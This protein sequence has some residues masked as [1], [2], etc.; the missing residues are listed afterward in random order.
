LHIRIQRKTR[1]TKKSKNFKF[2]KAEC[3]LWTGGLKASPVA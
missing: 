3:Y 2:L 1:P